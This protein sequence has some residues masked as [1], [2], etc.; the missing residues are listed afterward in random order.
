MKLDRHLLLVGCAL[1]LVLPLA[2][3]ST[4]PAEVEGATSSEPAV[5][6][7]ASPAQYVGPIRV[8]RHYPRTMIRA[9]L[10]PPLSSPAVAANQAYKTCVTG[11][12]P[13]P[14]DISTGVPDIELAIFSDDDYGTLGSGG[15]VTPFFQGVLA[16]LLTWHAI[17][18][19]PA[20]PM[21]PSGTPRPAGKCDFVYVVSATSGAYMMAFDVCSA[22]T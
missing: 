17:S 9:E 8:A 3:G 11:P 5:A 1:G 19:P 10:P 13:C 20:G 12:Q 4:V 16:W 21:V 22:Q 14:L 2:C 6:G 15:K 18:L 7:L